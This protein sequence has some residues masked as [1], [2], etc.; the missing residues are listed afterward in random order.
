M[1]RG[2]FLA[3]SNPVRDELEPDFNAWYEERH[4]KEI[5]ALDGVRSCRRF[6]LAPTQVQDGDGEGGHR[7]LALYDVD[8]DDWSNFVAA[9][10]D[11][12]TDGRVTIN[13]EVIEL[14]PMPATMLF[15]EVGETRT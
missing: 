13:A 4:V 11:G 12:F 3:L 7:Y 2:I 10:R 5:M 9:M 14:D 6:R 8:V 15:E 1:A